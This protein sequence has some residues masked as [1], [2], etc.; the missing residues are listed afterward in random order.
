MWEDGGVHWKYSGDVS[1]KEIVEASTAIY[2]DPRFDKLRYKLVDFLEVES[3]EI[4]DANVALIA[5]QH[6]AAETSNP[7]IKNAILITSEL[8]EKA[9]KFSAFFGDSTWPIK[10]FYNLDEANDWI[11]RKSSN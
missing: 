4:D 5:F 11:G 1:G 2:G 8:S 6:I 9:N 7:N 10:V 3:L